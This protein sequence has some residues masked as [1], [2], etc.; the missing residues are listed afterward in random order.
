VRALDDSLFKEFFV[1]S[2]SELNKHNAK[3]I[4]ADTS[5]GF[6]C[7]VSLEDAQIGD[8]MLAIHYCHHNVESAYKS[9]GPIFIRKNALEKAT[10]INTVPEMF[11]I[12]PQSIRA[13][14][15]TNEMVDAKISN[16]D[17][18]KDTI[19]MFF[20]NKSVSYLHIHNAKQGCFNCRV[21][22]I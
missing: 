7:R 14:D 4:I 3:L 10:H 18:V 8:T 21:D 19:R 6:P 13:Y 22:R 15:L 5:P 20:E 1:K 2:E 17:E 12:R 9:S 11:K 16:G